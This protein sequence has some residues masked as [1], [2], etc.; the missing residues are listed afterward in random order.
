MSLEDYQS[1]LAH[2][3]EL[4]YANVREYVEA[5][6]EEY[7][8]RLDV[9]RSIY[10]IHGHNEAFDAFPVALEDYAMQHEMEDE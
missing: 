8:V 6:A 3:R 9:A 7:G 1:T 4:G 5:T 10:Q 2:C